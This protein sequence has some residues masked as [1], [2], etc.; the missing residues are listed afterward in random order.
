MH[1][2]VSP[3]GRDPQVEPRGDLRSRHRL[4][5]E[6]VATVGARRGKHLRERPREQRLD[7][8][9][10]PAH[11]GCRGD[12]LGPY[13][14]AVDLAH[15]ERL[16][17]RLVEAGHRAE[18]TR[19]QVQLVLNH[20][21]GRRQWRGKPRALARLRSPVETLRVDPVRTTEQRSGLSD[22]RQRG[23][24]VHRR[25]QEG[26]EPPV[27]RLV[28]GH[29]WQR[30]VTRE[31]ALEVRADDAQ[32]AGLIVVGQ[33]REGVRLE[34]RSAPGAILERNRPSSVIGVK[35]ARTVRPARLAE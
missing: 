23:E 25:D 26:W 5:E 22:P 16:D 9:L 24:L 13:R 33:E 1:L 30:A 28:H 20:E 14:A 31:V 8:V 19:D 21:V 11:G 29:D 18:R 6:R 12:D 15:A 7:L 3:L 35:G 32:F 27:D 17:R 4:R 2:R 10:R 34:A